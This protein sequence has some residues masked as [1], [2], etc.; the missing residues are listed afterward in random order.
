MCAGRHSAGACALC[1]V[2]DELHMKQGCELD[3]KDYLLLFS[4]ISLN[5]GNFFKN[6]FIKE[7]KV[8]KIYGSREQGTQNSEFF[9]A[10]WIFC[11][12]FNA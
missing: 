12:D 1:Y 10:F 9:C 8:Y 11:M 7:K 3:N 4:K 2:V 5:K 6:R